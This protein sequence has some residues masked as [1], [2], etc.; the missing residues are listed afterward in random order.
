MKESLGGLYHYDSVARSL[1]QVVTGQSIRCLDVTEEGDFWFEYADDETTLDFVVEK[2]AVNGTA[3][4]ALLNFGRPESAPVVHG[5]GL[6]RRVT[7]FLLDSLPVWFF[8]TAASGERFL[9]VD[10]LGA[11]VNATWDASARIRAQIVNSNSANL[12]ASASTFKVINPYRLVPLNLIPV[13][14]Q[15]NAHDA[16]QLEFSLL[17]ENS[18]LKGVPLLSR[19]VPVQEQLKAVPHF[20]RRDE[21]AFLF[22]RYVEANFHRGEDY[23]PIPYYGYVNSRCAVTFRAMSSYGVDSFLEPVL[24]D[25]S[26]SFGECFHAWPSGYLATVEL[27]APLREELLFALFGIFALRKA[28]LARGPTIPEWD[29]EDL[30][31]YLKRQ[32][33]YFRSP[34]GI[35]FGFHLG[36]LDGLPLTTA[37]GM[38]RICF[39]H[40]SDQTPAPRKVT[41]S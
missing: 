22:H 11:W 26:V 19:A 21:S 24:A 28:M 41:F 14:W 8:H 4:V 39:P 2:H 9:R 33:Q 31:C 13:S 40:R 18:G 3:T 34:R 16:P 17:T 38:T 35:P 37:L 5:Y 32:P 25:S 10:V 30:R 36:Q 23:D 12:G 29:S 20:S 7:F 15:Y 6:W 27:T 1:T